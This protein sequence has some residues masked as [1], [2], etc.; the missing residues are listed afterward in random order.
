MLLKVVV[1]GMKEFNLFYSDSLRQFLKSELE[2]LK[3]N[4]CFSNLKV[5]LVILEQDT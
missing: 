3:S 5:Q 2:T 1:E 4:V